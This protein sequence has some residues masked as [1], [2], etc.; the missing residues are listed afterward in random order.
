MKTPT[1]PLR[2]GDLV[3]NF[4]DHTV[5]EVSERTVVG[6]LL[7]RDGSGASSTQGFYLLTAREVAQYHAFVQKFTKLTLSGV[8]LAEAAS[9]KVRL[10]K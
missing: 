2:K 4:I 5:K 1:R 6:T 7:F 3:Y 9:K 8:R 10:L